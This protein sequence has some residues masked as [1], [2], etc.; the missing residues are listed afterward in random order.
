MYFVLN[1]MCVIVTFFK[2]ICVLKDGHNAAYKHGNGRFDGWQLLKKAE[3]DYKSM[4]DQGHY[5]NIPNV[6]LIAVLSISILITCLNC[7]VLIKRRKLNVK[8]DIML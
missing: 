7:Y 3:N 8:R 5:V 1:I 6:V 4:G 2:L